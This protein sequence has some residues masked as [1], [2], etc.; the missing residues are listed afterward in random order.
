MAEWIVPCNVKYFDVFQ[1]FENNDEIAFKRVGS[2]QE[3][4]IA[5]IYLTAPYS[6]IRFRCKVVSGKMSDEEL[7]NHQYAIDKFTSNRYVLLKLESEYKEG[8]LPLELLKKNGLGQVQR[9]SRAGK[10]L[11]SFIEKEGKTED[12]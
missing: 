12:K 6:E 11:V 7:S 10:E 3:N 2:L 9:Q 8:C 5:Y 1:H 4:D